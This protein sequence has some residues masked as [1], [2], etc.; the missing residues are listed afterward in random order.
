MT[1]RFFVERGLES[2]IIEFQ[3]GHARLIVL[4]PKSIGERQSATGADLSTGYSSRD[5][6]SIQSSKTWPKRM[7][8]RVACKRASTGSESRGT[9][10]RS[11][12]SQSSRSI[13]CVTASRPGVRVSRNA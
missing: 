3:G 6:A 12:R 10:L 9:G 5:D 11:Y 13:R 2:F 1:M 7:H 8:I 4:R